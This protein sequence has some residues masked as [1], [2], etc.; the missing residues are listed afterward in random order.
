MISFL[1]FA[2]IGT[3][4]LMELLLISNPTVLAIHRMNFFAA[5][6]VSP[7]SPD[8]AKCSDKLNAKKS[9]CFDD[10]G[11]VPNGIHSTLDQNKIEQLKKDTC[12]T[13]FGK[14]DCLKKEISETCSQ[15]EWNKF[16]EQFVNL[17]YMLVSECDFS[18]LG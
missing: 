6:N 2:V 15:Q 14:N 12:K 9:A 7:I 13:Y 5:L 17:S 16:R 1:Q 3:I 8:F 11:P 10:W 4:I 18:R